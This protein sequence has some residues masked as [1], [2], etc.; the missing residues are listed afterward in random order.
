MCCIDGGVMEFFYKN[1]NTIRVPFKFVGLKMPTESECKIRY[2]EGK[3]VT[4]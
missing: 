3:R 2:N 4:L 1:E